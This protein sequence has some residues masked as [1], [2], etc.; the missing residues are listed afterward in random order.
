[1]GTDEDAM[2]AAAI[3]AS[4]Q[5]LDTRETDGEAARRREREELLAA[6]AAS[7]EDAGIDLDGSEAAA[8]EAAAEEERLRAEL[9]TPRE[10]SRPRPALS[11][12]VSAFAASQAASVA[13]S[14]REGAAA[15]RSLGGVGMGGAHGGHGMMVDDDEDAMLQAALAMSRGPLTPTL[16]PTSLSE[17][18]Q[19]LLPGGRIAISGRRLPRHPR[20][21]RHPRRAL[22][23]ALRRLRREGS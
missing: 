19:P 5:D 10:G 7:R 11:G 6:L 23:R 9:S 3:A 17:P 16:T 20:H 2:L 13:A 8:R 14:A 1:M 18:S 21:P 4:E 12:G 15:P 22:R